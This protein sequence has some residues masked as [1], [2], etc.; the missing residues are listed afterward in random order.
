MGLSVRAARCQHGRESL[1]RFWICPVLESLLTPGHPRILSPY[2]ADPLKSAGLPMR[3]ETSSAV[4]RQRR[5]NKSFHAHVSQIMEGSGRENF[6]IECRTTSKRVARLLIPLPPNPDILRHA[7]A[8]QRL[9]REKAPGRCPDDRE[10]GVAIDPA[11]LYRTRRSTASPHPAV[12]TSTAVRLASVRSR[13]APA[14][15]AKPAKLA[16]RA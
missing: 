12:P 5:Q 1:R 6:D 11:G 3:V 10:H 9:P 4:A 14:D 8:W 16:S 2:R 13:C 15:D 7:A